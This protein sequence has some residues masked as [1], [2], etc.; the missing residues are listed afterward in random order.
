MADKPS[1]EKQLSALRHSRSEAV[2]F[3]IHELRWKWKY[4]EVDN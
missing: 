3:E 2:M 1:E 4:L